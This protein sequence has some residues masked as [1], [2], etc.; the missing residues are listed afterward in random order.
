MAPAAGA[1]PAAAG[2]SPGAY[3]GTREREGTFWRAVLIEGGG[4]TRWPT[5]SNGRV[6]P[7]ADSLHSPPSHLGP[8]IRP[9]P[10]TQAPSPPSPSAHLVKLSLPP[11]P[12]PPPFL[13]VVTPAAA[14]ASAVK[15][16]AA[17]RSSAPAT[18]VGRI[19]ALS[20]ESAFGTLLLGR[21]VH[22]ARATRHGDPVFTAFGRRQSCGA[23][24]FDY[25]E[26]M[27]ASFPVPRPESA[28]HPPPPPPPPGRP[29]GVHR[30]AAA[31]GRLGAQRAAAGEGALALKGG[32]FIPVE[33]G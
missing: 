31:D 30:V 12:P 22:G 9:P 20:S 17:L 10:P 2:A 11:S 4:G 32:A 19:G 25:P 15:E 3:A 14:A 16:W 5:V 13:P 29:D 28:R 26:K 18:Q 27:R 23:S 21:L 33:L 8:R 6:P 24:V 7:S 1:T